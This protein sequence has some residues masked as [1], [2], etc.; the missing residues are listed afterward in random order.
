VLVLLVAAAYLAVWMIAMGAAAAGMVPLAVL[1]SA[2]MGGLYFHHEIR[3][4]RSK[5][6]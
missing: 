6:G 2:I 5:R 4:L 3:A 1:F